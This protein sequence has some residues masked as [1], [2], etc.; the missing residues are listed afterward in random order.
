M[1]DFI[2]DKMALDDLRHASGNT[3]GKVVVNIALV[4]LQVA[5]AGIK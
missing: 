2:E 5:C 4:L 3:D 1:A